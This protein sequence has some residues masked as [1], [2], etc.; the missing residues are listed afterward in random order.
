MGMVCWVLGLT[1]AQMDALRAA[2]SLAPDLV[3]VVQSEQL[4]NRL[5]EHFKA[6]PPDQRQKL[7]TQRAQFEASPAVKEREAKAREKIIALEPLAP[8]LCLEKSWHIL[9]YLLTG[10]IGPANA[11]GDL[12]LTGE[13]LGEDLGYGPVRFHAPPE[14]RAFDVFLQTQDVSHLQARIDLRDMRLANVYALPFGKEPDDL[15]ESELRNE[16]ARFFPLL[17]DYVHK[18]SDLSD[19]LLVWI[20]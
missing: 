19:G 11:P 10:H 6:L 13:G 16:V 4:R 15:H 2:P 14:A 8:V 18:V 17:R 1:P 7:D 3:E 9:H 12:L 5:D 20:S